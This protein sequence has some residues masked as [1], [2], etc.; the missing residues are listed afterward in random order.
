MMT[1]I[2]IL[3]EKAKTIVIPDFDEEVEKILKKY[4]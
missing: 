1:D 2:E 4:L 3:E